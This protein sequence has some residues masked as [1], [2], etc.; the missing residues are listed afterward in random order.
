MDDNVCQVCYQPECPSC[1]GFGIERPPACITSSRL[2]PGQR[3]Y[4]GYEEWAVHPEEAIFILHRGYALVDGEKQPVQFIH[5]EAYV[6][7]IRVYGSDPVYALDEKY[8]GPETKERDVRAI[9]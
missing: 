2:L 7:Q 9:N 4:R 8:Y 1:G 3:E 6:T 5:N